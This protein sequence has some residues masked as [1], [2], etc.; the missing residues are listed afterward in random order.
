MLLHPCSVVVILIVL[1]FLYYDAVSVSFSSL[2]SCDR[3][4]IRFIFD[5]A[6][7]WPL[8]GVTALGG[9]NPV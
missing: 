1:T 7:L 3:A 2:G 8:A 5:I 9:I 4:K 6:F